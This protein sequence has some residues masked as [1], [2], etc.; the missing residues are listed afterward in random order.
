MP[1]SP[2]AKTNETEIIGAPSLTYLA[3]KATKRNISNLEDV[4]DMPWRLVK[5][6]ISWVTVPAQ[7]A[8]I[9]D[10]CPQ[11]KESTGN[12]W[13]RF[14]HRDIENA[15]KKL[16]RHLPQG[17]RNNISIRALYDKL[18]LEQ[19]RTIKQQQEALKASMNRASAEKYSESTF[20]HSELGVPAAEP[21]WFAPP[22]RRTFSEG[23]SKRRT[24]PK[25]SATNASLLPSQQQPSP[26]ETNSFLAKRKADKLKAEQE[27]AAFLAKKKTS[28]PAP[29]GSAR[30][31]T[32]TKSSSS[33][34][35][36]NRTVARPAAGPAAPAVR[37]PA[38]S[39][40]PESRK[41]S[42]SGAGLEGAPA[43]KRSCEERERALSMK[44][45]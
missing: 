18:L 27:R 42:A 8:K 44:K 43:A 16:S 34:A 45:K 12:L 38:A 24:V 2:P 11:V 20:M 1:S 26:A 41:R 10:Q 5:N 7:L 15:S 29:A 17:S 21:R 6:I 39:A 40:A 9:E 35:A 31:T 30:T 28:P 3:L 19:E 32:T 14:I 13:K 36:A 25:A 4:G 33:A 37:R 23:L 22:V